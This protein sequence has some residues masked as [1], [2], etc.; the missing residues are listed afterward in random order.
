MVGW[1]LEG[2]LGFWG[3]KAKSMAILVRIWVSIGLELLKPRLAVRGKSDG[4]L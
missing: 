1:R 2:P 3:A 4:L